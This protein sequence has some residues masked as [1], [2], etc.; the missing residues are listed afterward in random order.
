METKR[1]PVIAETPIESMTDYTKEL[2]A[3]FR[4]IN[5]GDIISGTVI[6]VNEEE[7][8][9]DLRYYTQGIIKAADMS[10][11]PDFSII[12]DIKVG[13]T[14]EATVMKADDGH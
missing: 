14:I 1:E 13:D 3:S 4:K 6:A 2:E 5:E 8:T 7:V 9:L 11:A 10:K 12:R